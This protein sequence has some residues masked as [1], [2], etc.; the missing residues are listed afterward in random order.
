MLDALA[1]ARGRQLLVAQHP[2]LD[3]RRV[4]AAEVEPRLGVRAARAPV[5]ASVGAIARIDRRG[6]LGVERAAVRV[7]QDPPPGGGG[8]E[9]LAGFGR[10]RP[11]ARAA[12]RRRP[13]RSARRGWSRRRG[14]APSTPVSADCRGAG[15]SRGSAADATASSDEPR[16]QHGRARSCHAGAQLLLLGVALERERDQAIEQ[17]RVRR[18]RSPP[19]SSRTC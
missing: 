6:E 2:P 17:R 15:A 11:A 4:G 12:A 13:G 8:V 16:T 19:T 10:R 3:A 18:R 1:V 7:E 9:H 14:R 5:Q